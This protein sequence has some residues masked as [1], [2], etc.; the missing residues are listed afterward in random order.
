MRPLLPPL[1]CRLHSCDTKTAWHAT[2]PLGRTS[3]GSGVGPHEAREPA[4]EG[5]HAA[6]GALRGE[7]LHEHPV[8]HR[9]VHGVELHS[10]LHAVTDQQL[11][12]RKDLRL[13]FA[14]K[15][16]TSSLCNSYAGTSTMW[17]CDVAEVLNF[18]KL[19]MCRPCVAAKR[20]RALAHP[21][22]LQP[23]FLSCAPRS[24]TSTAA[25]ARSP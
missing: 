18:S 15:R 6:A 17:K 19:K 22:R 24:G 4:V 16:C 2:R 8:Q 9:S 14:E 20:P 12:L 11:L 25:P 10:I 23:R 13:P 3:A 7:A 21:S 1:Q 5:V